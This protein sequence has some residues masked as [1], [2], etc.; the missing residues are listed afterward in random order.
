MCDS[1]GNHDHHGHEHHHEHDGHGEGGILCRVLAAAVLLAAGLLTTGWI[2]M[3]LF[4]AAYLAA[5]YD[6]LLAAAR[7]ISRG[8]VFDENFLMAVASLGAM[9]M[10]ECAEGVAVL[11]L[12]QV[13]EWFQHRAVEKSRAS[14]TALMDIRPDYAYVLRDGQPCRV[15]PEEVRPG[16]EIIIRPGEKVPLDG[17]VIAGVSS[18]NTVALTGESLPRDV[19]PGDRVISGCV[20]LSGIL[21]VQ[22]ESEYAQSTVARILQLMEKSGENKARSEKFITR[23][24]R[25]YTPLVCG[26]AA[27]LALVPPM[28]DGRWL[29]WLHRALTFLVISCPCAL[30]ISVPLTYFSGIGGASRK[31][32]LIKGANY[33]EALAG[34]KMVVFDKTGTLTRG[35]FAVADIRPAACTAEELLEMAALAE[36]ASSHPIARSI[37]TA[38]GREVDH[39]RLGAVEETAGQ[40]L[41]AQVDSAV[42]HAGNARLMATVGVEAP[43]CD[44]AGTVVHVA[45]DGVYQGYIVIDDVIRPTAAQAVGELKEL[46][47]RRLVMLTGDRRAAAEKIARQLGLTEYHSELLPENKVEQ[48]EQV[49]SGGTAAFV[50]DGINDAPVLRRADVGIAMG[51]MGSDAAIE[52]AD[53]VLMDDDPARLATAVRHARKTLG[54]V[55]QNIGFSLG[56]KLVVM[57][58]GALGLANMWM[59]VFADVGVTM[60]AVINAMRA[61]R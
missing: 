15:S 53:V 52:A 28:F 29:E 20:N 6:I 32:V 9:L 49:L 23:F 19:A 61:M 10:G 13:G 21:N 42:I 48:M 46:G 57:L 8:R 26:A 27:L 17:R 38:Y 54:I 58:L 55:R 60:L 40:G 2:S 43:A 37:L 50:G 12:Y 47:V 4:I 31:G 30:V 39:Q 35:E 1:C 34:L 41:R 5:G 33:L 59:A 25:V 18:L 14:I 51:G 24:A 56:V 22:V 16:E 7:N 11:A 36:S 3:A 44:T 45:R